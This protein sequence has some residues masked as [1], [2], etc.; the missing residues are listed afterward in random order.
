[1]RAKLLSLVVVIGL[2]LAG[3]SA[4]ASDEVR[5]RGSCTSGSGH[6]DLRVRR[7]T[8]TSLR[9]RFSIENAPPGHTWQLFLSDNGSGVF[10]RSKVSI[11]DGEVRVRKVIRDRWGSDRIKAS[12]VDLTTGELCAGSL[13]Y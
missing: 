6:W 13:R 12:G 11:S 2:L 10:A 4:G 8:R 9:V 1:M 5:R 3:T 7:E